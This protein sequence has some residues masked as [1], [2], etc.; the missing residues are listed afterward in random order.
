MT[1][2]AY[3]PRRFDQIWFIPL[4]LIL[5]MKRYA[6][7]KLLRKKR[8]RRAIQY[9]FCRFDIPS[10]LNGCTS[11]EHRYL[12]SSVRVLVLL[13]F[14]GIVNKWQYLKT[15]ILFQNLTKFGRNPIQWKPQNKFWTKGFCV[16][17]TLISMKAMEAMCKFIWKS[18]DW[19]FWK[20]NKFKILGLFSM[21]HVTM[22]MTQI[23]S[24]GSNRKLA[25][26]WALGKGKRQ[27]LGWNDKQTNK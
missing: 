25:W 17:S 8:W 22:A 20:L 13:T 11:A 9:C 12:R 16:Q 4:L 14:I 3:H 18:N 10:Y 26:D 2:E 27:K 15:Y 19:I 6:S 24:L 1:S 23:F 7:N 21:I 5:N